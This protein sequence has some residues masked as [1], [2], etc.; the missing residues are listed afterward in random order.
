[1]H[2]GAPLPERV[3]T[4]NAYL[5]ALPVEAAL[6]AGAADRDHRALRRQRRDARAR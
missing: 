6:D 5:G 4:A 2:S 1:M 3:L